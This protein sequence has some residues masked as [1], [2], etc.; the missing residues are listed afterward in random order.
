MQQLGDFLDERDRRHS[1]DIY[2]KIDAQ[3][4]DG[5]YFVRRQDN[6]ELVRA[7]ASNLGVRYKPGTVVICVNPG[8]SGLNRNTG[9]TIIGF[10]GLA[11]KNASGAPKMAD[12]FSYSGVAITKVDPDPVAIIAEPWTIRTSAADNGWHAVT[13]G[14]GLFVAVSDTG[15]GNRVMT[16]GRKTKTVDVHGA[17]FT[18]STAVSYSTASLTNAVAPVVTPTKIT[19]S[20]LVE[21]GILPGIYDLIIGGHILP[22]FQVSSQ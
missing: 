11:L 1:P 9:L 21:P 20:V 2:A 17:G 16:Q 19:L 12:T 8:A 14:N 10:P 4:A 6:D 3:N 7:T 5:S 22:I 18:D 15:I 13:F